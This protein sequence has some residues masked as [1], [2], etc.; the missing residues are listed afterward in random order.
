VPVYTSWDVETL[1]RAL[2]D[3]SRIVYILTNS[4][5]LT[6]SETECLHRGIASNL[7]RISKDTGREFIIISRGDST[8]RGHYPLETSVLYEELRRGLT[9]D[10]E[11]IVPFFLE[12]GRFTYEDIHYVKE[13][14]RLIPAG[15]TEFARDSAF[16]YKSSDLK[17]WIEEKTKGLYPSDRVVSISLEE[18]RCRRREE[19]VN[20]LMGIR[21]FGKVIVNAASYTDLKVLTICLAEVIGRGRR[22]IFRSAASLVQTIGGIHPRPLLTREDFYP[23]GNLMR[24]PGIIVVGSYVNKTTLQLERLKEL[25]GIAF[26]EMD[27]ERVRE[28]VSFKHEIERIV[29]ETHRAFGSGKDVCLYTSRRYLESAE[30]GEKSLA[31]SNRVSQGLVEA[32]T[33]IKRAPGFIIAKGGITSSDIGVKALHVKRAMVMGQIQ[34][35]IPVWKLGE[36]SAFPGIPYVIFP[37]NVGG[38]DT[39]KRAA[40]ILR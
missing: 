26:I 27:V 14:D 32:V 17:E 7:L 30:G 22:F 23:Q 5:A 6:A 33:S 20:K 21:D 15:R 37:G 28:E 16:G 8:L 40:E 4:R 25:P 39:L 36:E 31:F 11:I 38:E 2:S 34:P 35:G 19:I 3:E 9:V 1:K 18:L 12:G 24:N 10:G 13:G 29:S